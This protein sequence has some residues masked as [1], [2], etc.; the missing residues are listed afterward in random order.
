MNNSVDSA[1]A[2]Q[3]HRLWLVFSFAAWFHGATAENTSRTQ[4]CESHPEIDH[5][6]LSICRLDKLWQMHLF[7]VPSGHPARHR[8]EVTPEKG[9]VVN[10][11][12]GFHEA[13]K[14]WRFENLGSQGWLPGVP[15]WIHAFLETA[16]PFGANQGEGLLPNYH[17]AG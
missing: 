3:Y 12:Y 4:Q 6:L 8:Y 7:N 1:G 9:F 17:K 11:K 16:Q 5:F 10:Q 14:D 2:S 13:P 15:G